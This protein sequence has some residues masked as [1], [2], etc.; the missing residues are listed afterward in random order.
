ME[1]TTQRRKFIQSAIATIGTLLFGN[2]LRAEWDENAYNKTE[3]VDS[4]RSI[5][6]G[7][8]SNI[9][10]GSNLID[11]NIPEIAENGAIVPVEI[12]SKIPDTRRIFL[13]AEKNPQP[14]V[15]DVVFSK[16]T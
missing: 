13:F 7:D 2:T 6:I 14:L 9:V 16:Y 10:D 3:I 5:G 12:H 8:L 1:K 15:A 4:I 11:L